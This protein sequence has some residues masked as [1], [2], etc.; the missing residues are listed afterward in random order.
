ML[1]RKIVNLAKYILS[2]FVFFVVNDI[3]SQSLI[4]INSVDLEKGLVK[5]VKKYIAKKKNV[6]SFLLISDTN[7]TYDAPWSL[8]HAYLLSIGPFYDGLIVEPDITKNKFEDIISYN[9]YKGISSIVEQPEAF[10]L[11]GDK[12]VY[13]QSSLDKL[14]MPE[15]SIFNKERR[16]T[17]T[18]FIDDAQF[19]LLTTR[20]GRPKFE[21]SQFDKDW[22]KHFRIVEDPFNLN[23]KR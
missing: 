12:K 19:I 5:I 16:S 8:H 4:R 10:M 1:E 23:K 18:K 21:L 14:L 15:D 20:L 22:L 3:F 2:V 11:I 9:Y 7:F 13:F 6:D 17:I